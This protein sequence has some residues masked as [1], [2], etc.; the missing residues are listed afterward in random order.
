M[1]GGVAPYTQTGNGLLIE[2]GSGFRVKGCNKQ[3]RHRETPATTTTRSSKRTDV[4]AQGFSVEARVWSSFAEQKHLSQ[5]LDKP[6]VTRVF[7]S[8]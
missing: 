8:K 4:S 7:C 1:V 3:S 2:F 6:F 5:E